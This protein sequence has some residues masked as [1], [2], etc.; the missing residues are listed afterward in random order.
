[1]DG[2]KVAVLG[3]DR[4]IVTDWELVSVATLDMSL[5]DR[6]ILQMDK[7]VFSGIVI[8]VRLV[9]T[10]QDGG[11]ADMDRELLARET[12]RLHFLFIQIYYSNI[13][14]QAV[15][16]D[17]LVEEVFIEELDKMVDK[18]GGWKG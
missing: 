7:W 2:V 16:W 6:D 9:K 8:T 17:G 1:M 4:L 11:V 10:K 12:E 3:M 13:C 5:L 18:M 15:D 14:L